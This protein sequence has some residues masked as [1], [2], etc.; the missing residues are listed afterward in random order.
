[1]WRRGCRRLSV[2]GTVGVHTDHTRQRADYQSARGPPAATFQR[3]F[4]SAT[5]LHLRDTGTAGH[6][7]TP[8]LHSTRSVAA[9]IANSFALQSQQ[10]WGPAET[11]PPTFR[12][13]DQQCI[14]PPNFLAVVFKKQEISQ[15]EC[16]PV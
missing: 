9:C 12:L 10:P 14:G 2:I 6:C 7:T 3:P 16:D 15:Q 5:S 1:M 13:G 4:C 11:G 8:S